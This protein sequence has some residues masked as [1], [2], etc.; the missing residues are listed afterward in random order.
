MAAKSAPLLFGY[1]HLNGILVREGERV[2][3]GQPIGFVG[4]NPRG[5]DA[6]H[7]H[8]EAMRVQRPAYRPI[9]PAPFLKK[10]EHSVA[11]GPLVWPVPP[12]PKSGQVVDGVV[13]NGRLPG[14][15]SG[16]KDV[17]PS[18]PTHDGVDIMY[19]R[20]DEDTQGRGDG[21]GAAR[22]VMPNGIMA[23]AVGPG[24]IVEAGEIGT[25]GRVWLE[26]DMRSPAAAAADRPS[27]RAYVASAVGIGGAAYGGYR[28]F[29]TRKSKRKRGK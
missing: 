25:G 12:L 10:M 23:V 26:L 29:K 9:N 16:H 17:N 20:E 18:R 28:Y 5:S 4:N 2:V 22:W 21:K 13:L 7:L 27:W 3:A 19:P 14:M 15:S 24:I 8:F 6:N 11:A 1:F